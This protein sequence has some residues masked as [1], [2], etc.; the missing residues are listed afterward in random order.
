MIDGSAG[1]D[2]IEEHWRSVL[3]TG[4]VN[5]QRRFRNILGKL[6]HDPR[7]KVC[8][9]PYQGIGAPLMKVLGRT[10]SNLT[11]KLCNW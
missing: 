3:L 7:C 8:N 6:P 2:E 1:R 5:S 9:A 11:P 10:P 4:R